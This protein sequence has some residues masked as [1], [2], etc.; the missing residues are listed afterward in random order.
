MSCVRIL[1]RELV[2][3]LSGTC[4]R[5][6][7][8][9]H[10]GVPHIFATSTLTKSMQPSQAIYEG[11]PSAYAPSWPPPPNPNRPGFERNPRS[12]QSMFTSHAC[13]ACT[14]LPEG[15]EPDHYLPINQL[16]AW[17][18]SIHQDRR[19][20][21]EVN[22]IIWLDQAQG[23]STSQP[24]PRQAPTDQGVAYHKTYSLQGA[25][26]MNHPAMRMASTHTV[27]AWFPF[28]E[29]SGSSNDYHAFNT[30]GHGGINQPNAVRNLP[31]LQSQGVSYSEGRYI[32]P[33][34]KFLGRVL[35]STPLLSFGLL[36][37]SLPLIME[38]WDRTK[39]ELTLNLSKFVKVASFD[40]FSHTT[41]V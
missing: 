33:R 6:N 5:E 9:T 16:N 12:L 32:G 10:L 3:N 21:E 38:D 8:L 36:L 28:T 30:A 20:N 25:A 41:V 26:P 15:D 18:L 19:T 31:Q 29:D 40:L 39:T 17:P 35:L 2:T 22:A 23:A 13:S 11:F 4:A 27:G 24:P 7:S 37:H 14:K 1:P 34:I